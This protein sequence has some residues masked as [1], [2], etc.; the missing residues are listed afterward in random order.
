MTEFPA[1]YPKTAIP[2]YPTRWR[3]RDLRLAAN[4]EATEDMM[5]EREA[6]GRGAVF[7]IQVKPAAI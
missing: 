4:Q 6:A 5:R 3:S 1:L 7:V 2:S